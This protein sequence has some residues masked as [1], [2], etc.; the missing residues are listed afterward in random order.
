MVRSLTVRCLPW[1]RTQGI[2]QFGPIT[3]PCALGRTGISHFKHEGDGATPVG[4]FE[5][6]HVYYRA[7]RGAHPTTG[8]PTEVIRPNLGW[9]DD[10][11]H[12]RYNRPVDL[13]FGASHEI[14]WRDDHLYDIV[15]VLDC[16]M[17]PAVKRR[18]SAIFFHLARPGYHPTEG[19]VAVA[20][21]HM[22]LLLA[23]LSIGDDMI[24]SGY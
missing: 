16:N 15:V 19:C 14:M 5:L 2:L 18:G 12:C 6:L 9:C 10:A 24:I 22:R 3:I 23:G 17:Y 1:R 4:R 11:G 21:R 7:D 20:P 13:P 8:L